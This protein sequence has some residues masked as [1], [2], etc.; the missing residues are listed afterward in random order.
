MSGPTPYKAMKIGYNLTK[1]QQQAIVD[2]CSNDNDNEYLYFILTSFLQK[3]HPTTEDRNLATA[4]DATS[5]LLLPANMANFLEQ[6]NNQP[7]NRPCS[8]ELICKIQHLFNSA[9]Y[10]QQHCADLPIQHPHHTGNSTNLLEKSTQLVKHLSATNH[11][12]QQRVAQEHETENF[13]TETIMAAASVTNKNDEEQL[14]DMLYFA[15][16]NT[17]N[18]QISQNQVAIIKNLLGSEQFNFLINR[19]GIKELNFNYDDLRMLIIGSLQHSATPWL[20]NDFIKNLL[21]CCNIPTEHLGSELNINDVTSSKIDLENKVHACKTAEER[22]ILKQQL[23]EQLHINPAVWKR[24]KNTA[25]DNLINNALKFLR[26]RIIEKWQFIIPVRFKFNSLFQSDFDTISSITNIQNWQNKPTELQEFASNEFLFHQLSK[27]DFKNDAIVPIVEPNGT[28]QFYKVKNLINQNGISGLALVPCNHQASLE[29]KIVFNGSGSLA[30]QIIDTENLTQ[31]KEFKRHKKELLHNLNTVVADFKKILIMDQ[32]KK[33]SLNIGGHGSSGSLAQHLIN[34]LITDKAAA[35]YTKKLLGPKLDLNIQEQHH[36]ENTNKKINTLT[37]YKAAIKNYFLK[38]LKK[39]N[40]D[41]LIHDN[42]H[43]VSINQF[44]LSTVNS[45]GVP[46][47]MRHNFIQSLYLLQNE[48]GSDPFS[49]QCNKIMVNG[50]PGQQTGGTDL[51]AYVPHKLMPTKL[52]KFNP[53]DNTSYTAHFKQI[54]KSAA[55]III[56]AVLASH[57][58]LIPVLVVS[59]FK[60]NPLKEAEKIYD[61]VNEIIDKARHAHG[62]LHFD[63]PS[64]NMA[65]YQIMSNEPN[66]IFHERLNIELSTKIKVFSCKPYKFFKK[67]LYES[68]RWV[69]PKKT[70]LNQDP[71]PIVLPRDAQLFHYSCQSSDREELADKPTHSK[72]NSPTPEPPKK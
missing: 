29:I 54:A 7:R 22:E 71:Q 39:K 70:S 3:T 4:I 17:L 12:H 50:D 28:R 67:C 43:L 41:N 8:N 61:N 72:T 44:K 14:I 11:L 47:K 1:D 32:Q 36:Q 13:V 63:K 35:L 66:H 30:Q 65:A 58:V 15:V 68:Y 23:T 24:I 56:Q 53:T 19:Y 33:I 42:N 38:Q 64:P 20:E 26:N 40:L 55:L 48:K 46:E 10:L 69:Q 31:H 59:F 21:V 25:R 62:D 9:Q 45:G 18:A 60:A 6:I 37:T 16:Q 27:A 57:I 2:F 51:A 49:I 52:I 34:E 5:A